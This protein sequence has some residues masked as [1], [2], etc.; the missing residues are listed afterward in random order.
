MNDLMNPTK[1]GYYMGRLTGN[2][3]GFNEAIILAIIMIILFFVF[4]WD[5]IKKNQV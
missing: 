5:Y 4:I 2:T 3:G 1:W